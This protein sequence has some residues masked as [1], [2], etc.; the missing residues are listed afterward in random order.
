MQIFAFQ[1]TRYHPANGDP[2]RLAAPPF[3]QIDAELATILRAESH[4]FAHL[5]RPDPE[6][7]DPHGAAAALQRRWLEEDVLIAEDRPSLYLYETRLAT[8]GSR[9]GLCGLLGLA[10][11]SVRPHERT[12]SKTVDERLDLVRKIR[13]D[14]EPIFLLCNDDGA[15]DTELR[16]DLEGAQWLASYRDEFGHTH[17]IAAIQEPERIEQYQ[18]LLSGQSGLIADGHHRYEVSRLYAE[19]R[20]A[21]PRT[22]PACKLVVLVSLGSPHLSIDPIHRAVRQPVN[23]DRFREYVRETVTWTGATGSG[24][25]L[26]AATARQPALGVWE[27]GGDPVLCTLDR[28]RILAHSDGR[29]PDLPVTLFHSLFDELGWDDESASDGTIVYRSDPD[30]LYREMLEHEF[31]T[32]FWL[33]PMSA[34]D[35]SE[36]LTVC[37]LMPPKS[38]RFLPKLASGLVWARHDTKLM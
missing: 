16:I 23:L 3:D 29:L 14:L 38:T 27:R 10:A 20:R 33:P 7:D 9:L 35:F 25:A 22:A 4:H 19:E 1:G 37:E 2:G 21:K 36:A 6:L 11:S 34:E 8:G 12:V 13:T 17:S 30:K 26:A 28:D 5:T 18:E 15:L 31:S 32:S 24:L